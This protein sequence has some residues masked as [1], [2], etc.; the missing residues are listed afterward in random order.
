[1]GSE[2][3]SNKAWIAEWPRYSPVFMSQSLIAESL[4]KRMDMMNWIVLA[5]HYREAACTDQGSTY[6]PKTLERMLPAPQ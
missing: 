1:M 4:C 2:A 6:A 5:A 3:F